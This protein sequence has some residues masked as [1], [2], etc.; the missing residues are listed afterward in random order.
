MAEILK[1]TKGGIV[2]KKR[3][4]ELR[5]EIYKEDFDYWYKKGCMGESVRLS[6]SAI[7]TIKKQQFLDYMKNPHTPTDMYTLAMYKNYE[8]LESEFYEQ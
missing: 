8:K 5:L 2:N 4:K 3:K 6:G 7:I 1:S